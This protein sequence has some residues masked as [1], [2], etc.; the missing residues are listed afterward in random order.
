MITCLK[1]RIRKENDCFT[2]R[3]R[4]CDE[5]VLKYPPLRTKEEKK[6]IVKEWRKKNSEKMK[7]Y[8]REYSRKFVAKKLEDNPNYH[9]ERYQEIIKKNP[10]TYKNDRRRKYFRDRRKTD[11]H[12]RMKEVLKGRLYNALR[13]QNATKS[14]NTLD[15]LGCDLEFFEKYMEDGF[16]PEMSWENHGEFWEADHVVPIDFFDLASPLHQKISFHYLNYN[17]LYWEDNKSKKN[18]LASLDHLFLLLAHLNVKME[19]FINE[20]TNKKRKE[21]AIQALS[22]IYGVE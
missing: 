3:E 8:N 10:E 4:R 22:L 7:Q 17:P 1:C 13:D 2:L 14:A 19:D 9:K 5:C 11:P 6:A 21:K 18:K 15:L 20:Y 16:T 12:F